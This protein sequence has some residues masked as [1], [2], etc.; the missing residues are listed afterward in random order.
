[1]DAKLASSEVGKAGGEKVQ[2]FIKKK[3]MTSAQGRSVL[4]WRD[5]WLGLGD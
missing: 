2:F 3:K 5:K 4:Q 1:M